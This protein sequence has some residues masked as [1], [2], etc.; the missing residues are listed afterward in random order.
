MND[1]PTTRTREEV[2]AF[3]ETILS[4][5]LTPEF[6]VHVSKPGN[7]DWFGDLIEKDFDRIEGKRQVRETCIRT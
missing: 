2:R 5:R 3:L 7:L 6:L 4:R 1:S